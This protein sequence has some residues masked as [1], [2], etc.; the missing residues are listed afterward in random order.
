[1]LAHDDRFGENP[2]SPRL[3]GHWSEFL[4]NIR[5]LF[6]GQQQPRCFISYAWPAAGEGRDRLQ[7]RLLSLKKDLESLGATVYL[8]V[9]NLRGDINAYMDKLDICDHVFL[10]GT[11][12][13]KARLTEAN[14]NNAKYEYRRLLQLQTT[15]PDFIL[16]LMFEGDFG[17]A[18]PPDMGNIL[19]RDFRLS[20]QSWAQGRDTYLHS[21]SDI[22]PLGLIPLIYNIHIG[23]AQAAVYQA[24]LQNLFGRLHEQRDQHTRDCTQLYQQANDNAANGHYAAALQLYQQAAQRMHAAAAYRVGFFYQAED[25][26]LGPSRPCPQDPAAAVRWIKRGAE[27]G[28]VKSMIQTAERLA[29]QGR[30]T[31]NVEDY[32]QALHWANEAVRLAE[33][34]DRNQAKLTLTKVQRLHA[35]YLVK[36]KQDPQAMLSVAEHLLHSTGG[37]KAP[38]STNSKQ[39]QYGEALKLAKQARAKGKQEAD[40]LIAEIEQTLGKLT[41]ANHPRP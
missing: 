25:R 39:L 18:F 31:S 1:M 36:E 3:R 5:E 37:I 14:D 33:D 38:E 4:K 7:Q 6:A 8:D 32:N 23:S 9:A 21:M 24:H 10:I 2:D 30:D 27:F 19:I 22:T 40:V 34:R 17:T 35:E 16:P 15:N 29:Y 12:R 13:L 41:L 28:H 26:E 20:Y 11:P